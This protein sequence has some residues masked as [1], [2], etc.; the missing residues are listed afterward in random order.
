MQEEIHIGQFV[1]TGT[2]GLLAATAAIVKAMKTA[3]PGQKRKT[4]TIDGQRITV[5]LRGNRT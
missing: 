4:V 1:V 5:A 2:K 3:K